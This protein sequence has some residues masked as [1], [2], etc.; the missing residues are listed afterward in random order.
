M[1]ANDFMMQSMQAGA[2]V[3][4]FG[5]VQHIPASMAT[6]AMNQDVQQQHMTFNDHLNVHVQ[7][8]DSF[9]ETLFGR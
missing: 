9:W 5:N 3:D 2:S 8:P 4:Q 7:H 6:F 1:D